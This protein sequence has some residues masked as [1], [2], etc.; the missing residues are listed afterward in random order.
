MKKPVKITLISLGS[1]LLFLVLAVCITVAVVLSPKQLTK[2]VNRAAK[3]Y[4]TCNY[5]I[6]K[7][8]LTIFKTF[9]QL[10]IDI[11]DVLLLNPITGSPND[12]VLKV[13]HCLASLDIKELLKNRHVSVS[14][15]TLQDGTAHLFR[16]LAG[17]PNYDILKLPESKD[18]SSAPYTIDLSNVA[19]QHINV[20]YA[21]LPSRIY[22]GVQNVNAKIKGQYHDNNAAGDI[23]L[24]TDN[25]QF[26]TLDSS[27]LSVRFNHLDAGFDGSF[28]DLDHLKGKLDM[29]VAELQLAN[30][31][32][33]LINKENVRLKTTVDGTLSLQKLLLESLDLTYDQYKLQLSGDLQRDTANG[34]I[35]MD[36]TYRT[37]TWPIADVLEK[38]P[39]AIMSHLPDSMKLDGQVALGGTVKGTYN[40]QS[41]PV[42][43]SNVKLKD[44]TFALAGMPFDIQKINGEADLNLDLDHQTDLKIRSVEGKVRGNHVVV[45][46]T[47][48]DL[49]GKMLCNLS[50]DGTLRLEDFQDLLPES[51]TP[52]KGTAKSSVKAEFDYEQVK[53][54]Q[55]DK[56]IASGAFN[57]QNLDML[58]DDSLILR[59][60]NVDLQ[61][62]FPVKEKPYRID[63][64]M[65]VG[66]QSPHLYC[67]SIDF[68]KA[69]LTDANID[70][71]LN[72]I[73]DKTKQLKFGTSFKG[74]KATFDTDSIYAELLHPDGSFLMKDQDHLA[75]KLKESALDATIGELKVSTPS[76]ALDGT[77][78]LDRQ[79]IN[80]LMQWNPT[81]RAVMHN[82]KVEM[83]ELSLP[84]S[85][86]DLDID[87]TMQNCH[88]RS[89]KFK[90]GQSSFSLTGN[91]YDIDKFYRAEG[92]LN[93]K[94]NLTSPFIDLNEILDLVDGFRAPDSLMNTELESKED[95]PFIVPYGLDVTI[96]TNVDKVHYEDVDIRKVGGKIAVDD[97]VLVL[98]QMGFTSD[99]ARMQMTALYKTPR[100]NHLFLGLDFHLL[101]IKIAELIDMI[102]EVDTV[103]PMLKSFAGNAEFHFAIETYLKSNYDV[104]FS[105][106]RGAAAIN[107]HDL[108][109]LDNE[110]YR[111]I[112][113]LLKFKKGTTNK[114]DSLSAEV[115]IYKNEVD[116][117]PFLLAIDRY[118]AIISG[119]HNLDMTYNYNISLVSPIRLGLDIIGTDQ[120]KFKLTKAKY[121]TLFRPEKQ[122]VVEQNVM[123]LKRQINN[124]LR[125]NVRE[126]APEGE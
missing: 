119:R 39:A 113:K 104:K 75:L 34:D 76:L 32:N 19:L 37:E 86:P 12:T 20:D 106:L 23:N 48:R 29:D 85:I 52:C 47:V 62:R 25:F 77:A 41:M 109:V 44:A 98:D 100:R 84:L 102:P 74:Q 114:I 96:N 33:Q 7:T 82:G 99:A 118:K 1:L 105:T 68:F 21:D 53:N 42:V 117:Y 24:S 8:G 28:T 15:F 58:Y 81:M 124:T 95:N 56:M 116:V 18:T 67:E 92:L 93:G 97:G 9:P 60:N 71:F 2:I 91:L 122:N 3:D 112:S 123:N 54:L 27:Q 69:N 22:T 40:E 73:L 45:N 35:N 90:L 30:D 17:H 46:G 72:D 64:W 63:E 108:V 31:T 83:P 103:L 38:L 14:K 80:T 120:R 78:S 59:S 115:T 49:L 107:G 121:A 16:N 125:S 101:D 55:I 87:F 126:Q 26:R 89:S 66:I 65:E 110:T 51:I 111:K 4:L 11:Q 70:L 61:V 43:T 5:Q 88:F 13:D 36:L 6:G 94:L 10:G 79:G 57:I 50:L